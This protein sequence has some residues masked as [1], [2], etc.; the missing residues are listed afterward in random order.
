MKPISD[1]K[2]IIYFSVM[3]GILIL[4]FAFNFLGWPSEKIGD[5]AD[6]ATYFGLITS[7]LSILFIILTYK[8]QIKTSALLQFE[9]AF[10]QWYQIHI[11]LAKDLS[12]SIN[13]FAEN[14]IKPFMQ[15]KT[16]FNICCFM[17]HENPNDTRNI[18]RY[19]RSLY[20]MMK[21]IYLNDILDSYEKKKKY[22]DIIQ[23]RMTDNELL[24]ILYL[25]LSDKEFNNTDYLKN[26]SYKDLLDEAHIFKNLY[27][28]KKNKNFISFAFFMGELFPKTKKSF[29]FLKI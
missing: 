23:S 20:S 4:A 11:N 19:Y 29:R 26:K 15:D 5:W 9:S 27:Y 12:K 1:K 14:T 2:I 21:Y 17:N 8:S 22:Y 25:L 28:S 10:F 6:A 24:V 18:A 16:D 3:A 13:S 7:I